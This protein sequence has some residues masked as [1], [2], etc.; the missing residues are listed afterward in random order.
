MCFLSM[1]IYMEYFF[2]K[3]INIDYDLKA[4]LKCYVNIEKSNEQLYSFIL[5]NIIGKKKDDLIGSNV[6]ECDLNLL[7]PDEF[8]TIHAKLMV[9]IIIN[10]EKSKYWKLFIDGKMIRTIDVINPV[11]KKIHN[12][13]LHVSFVKQYKNTTIF[14]VLITDVTYVNNIINKTDV[15]T[16]DLR[17]ILKSAINTIID[18]K[19]QNNLMLNMINQ[20]NSIGP[21]KSI[22][23]T[24]SIG[25]IKSISP[26]IVAEGEQI[27]IINELLIEA[28]NMC[29]IVRKPSININT[30]KSF[31]SEQ[32]KMYLSIHK[33]IDKLK[34]IYPN[35]H[36]TYKII[37]SLKITKLQ[38]D[39]LW[40]LMLNIT[41]SCFN[42]GSRKINILIDEVNIED[43][44]IEDIN[45]SINDI[46]DININI[47]KITTNTNNKYLQI[48]IFVNEHEMSKKMVNNEIRKENDDLTLSYNEWK[49]HGGL[50][51]ISS[52]LCEGLI[53]ELSIIGSINIEEFTFNTSQVKLISEISDKIGTDNTS[54]T[55]TD[56]KI[57][58]LVDDVLLNLKLL[59]LKLAKHID[60]TFN[61]VNFPILTREEWQAN[62][63]FFIEVCDYIFIFAAN[64]MCGKEI[65][66]MIHCDII[67]TDIQMPL[68][69]GIDMIKSLVEGNHKPSKINKTKILIISGMVENDDDNIVD[70]ITKYKITFIE[71]GSIINCEKILN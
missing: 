54:S 34:T 46:N 64:G 30:Y 1:V 35:I 31:V 37:T 10:K 11:N 21:I 58:L 13:K 53:F 17:S 39:A 66:M 15:S 7:L 69:N 63:I 49:S 27:N 42:N 68:L 25:P 56:K 36:F 43:I 12:V 5:K 67:I 61:Y 55:K 45:H 19:K 51:T 18:V 70:I 62:G 16:H 48:K 50:I 57:V 44:N 38:S 3:K 4:K 2:G 6:N 47:H 65:A 24:N 32:D 9:D 33:Y 71:K 60:N 20:T 28:L 23:Q 41:K 40:N 29:S 22:S 26:I 14:N 8:R 59:Y 52:I